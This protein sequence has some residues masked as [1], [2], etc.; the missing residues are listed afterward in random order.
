MKEEASQI[1]RK[2]KNDWQRAKM[3]IKKA[4]DGVEKGHENAERASKEKT[5]SI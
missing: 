5:D 3:R 1:R 2:G 4:E